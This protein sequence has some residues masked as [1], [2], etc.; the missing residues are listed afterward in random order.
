M[1]IGGRFQELAGGIGLT[2][3]TFLGVNE[4]PNSFE[5]PG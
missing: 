4:V 1:E 3:I 5:G 2:G